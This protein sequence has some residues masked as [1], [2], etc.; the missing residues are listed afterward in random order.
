MT[1]RW[2]LWS[3]VSFELILTSYG[4]LCT[5]SLLPETLTMI[6]VVWGDKVRA[7]L[8][9]GHIT[10]QSVGSLLFLYT[11]TSV[12]VWCWKD[13]IIFS[14]QDFQ[15]IKLGEYRCNVKCFVIGSLHMSIWISQC[16]LTL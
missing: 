7:L 3:L 1:G 13:W 14:L 2:H 4:V 16:K 15:P 8:C 5:S 12:A 10:M 6:S 11:L 9:S